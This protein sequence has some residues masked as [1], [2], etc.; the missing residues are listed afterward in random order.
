MEHPGGNCR[1][2]R[3]FR[4]LIMAAVLLAFSP[5]PLTAEPADP[6]GLAN[7]KDVLFV[8]NRD[9]CSNGYRRDKALNPNTPWCSLNTAV[10][11]IRARDTVYV[12]KGEYNERLIQFYNKHYDR[13]VTIAGYPG[14][15]PVFGNY[16]QRYLSV[17]SRLWRQESGLWVTDATVAE[18][19]H[20][21]ASYADGR[22]LWIHNRL[23]DLGDPL[24][25][26]GIY[27]DPQK[28]RIY[29]RL[30]GDADPNRV[31]LYLAASS[32]RLFLFQNSS[33]I[34][35]K[36]IT[37]KAS[38][39]PVHVKRSNK[40]V[41]EGLTILGGARNG[42]YVTESEG[43][44][45][46]RNRIL[47]QS[48]PDWKWKQVKGSRQENTGIDLT[49]CGPNNEVAHNEIEGWFNGIMI[50]TRDPAQAANT[51]VHHN[52]I[53]KIM[54]DGIEI[55]D[56][57]LDSRIHNNLVYDALVGVS[58]SPTIGRNCAIYRNVLV[59]N[60]SVNAYGNRVWNGECFKIIAKRPT[61]GMTVAHNTCLGKG[62]VSLP[63]RKRTQENNRWVNN[64][65]VSKD[66]PIVSRS[67]LNVAGVDYDYNLYYR[68]DGG[69]LLSY[70]NSDIDS[71]TFSSLAQALK[72]ESDPETWDRHSIHQDPLLDGYELRPQSPAIN[73]GIDLGYERDFHDRPVRGKPDIGA[74][75]YHP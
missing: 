7:G 33:N 23:E 58:L 30:K 2:W 13:R 62:I 28:H 29:A 44:T 20:A 61:S 37:I 16:E 12:R 39:I 43:I 64:L 51:R 65:F 19:R 34:I 50:Q 36:G 9:N 70:W 24:Q 42:I 71:A 53:H 27:V 72:S 73:R 49:A 6:S 32:Y 10:A 40:I 75:E 8:A 46:A 17:P 14:E 21:F 22:P 59:A 15:N 60:R 4:L 26:E 55:E 35:L 3:D 47:F 54:D 68:A 63:S 48:D 11:K 69:P 25:P 31:P 38:T 45:V 57:C 52:I 74:I 67:G 1:L 18:S 66:K 56:Y 5:P 41:V